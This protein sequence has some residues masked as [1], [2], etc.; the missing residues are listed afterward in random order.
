MANVKNGKVVSSNFMGSQFGEGVILEPVRNANESGAGG[1]CINNTCACIGGSTCVF[2]CA[3]CNGNGNV[4]SG[5]G[6]SNKIK[7]YR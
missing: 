2:V 5:C 1:G 7:V 3:S 4:G 6:S